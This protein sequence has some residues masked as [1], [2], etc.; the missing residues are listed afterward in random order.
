[1]RGTQ[2]QKARSQARRLK[3]PTQPFD[4][5]FLF[6]RFAALLRALRASKLFA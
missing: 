5:Q 4:L 3:Q 6:A 1:M 2:K